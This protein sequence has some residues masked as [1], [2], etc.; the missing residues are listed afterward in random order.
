MKKQL[1]TN[2][3][4]LPLVALLIGIIAIFIYYGVD[5]VESG[6]MRMMLAM[7]ALV[8]CGLVIAS[9]IGIFLKKVPIENVFVI[10]AVF[11]GGM[12]SIIF[13]PYSAPDENR[14]IETAYYYSNLV[15]LQKG[16]QARQGDFQDPVLTNLPSEEI[17]KD[18]ITNTDVFYNDAQT[19]LVYKD[20]DR[21]SA[22][23]YLYLPG[24]LGIAVGRIFHL[25]F[26]QF[27]ILGHG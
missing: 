7:G 19:T 15:L 3:A 4:F 1:F 12:F 16:E 21:V 24:T 18:L 25:G 8:T 14:H 11:I 2:R 20:L 13:T 5:K 17:Y 22:P 27:Y 9:Y 26:R 10:A 6:A 23:P